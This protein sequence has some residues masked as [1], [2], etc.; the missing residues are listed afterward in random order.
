MAPNVKEMECTLSET[1]D[2]LPK[3]VAPQAA[4]RKYNIIY[5]NVLTF[6]F[7]HIAALYGLYL[8][9]TVATWKTLIFSKYEIF[10]I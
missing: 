1:E 9:C 2:T 5:L 3:L 7:G 8:A 10:S 6:G 4:P